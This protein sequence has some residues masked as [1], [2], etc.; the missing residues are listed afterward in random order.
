LNTK[1]G[2]KNDKDPTILN[3]II[4]TIAYSFTDMLYIPEEGYYHRSI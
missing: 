3:H 2:F 1:Q 4:G